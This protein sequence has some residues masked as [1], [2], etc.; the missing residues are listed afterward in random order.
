MKRS[1]H[2]IYRKSFLI[3]RLRDQMMLK[4]FMN[5]F[6]VNFLGQVHRS[7]Y[8]HCEKKKHIQEQR[9]KDFLRKSKKPMA[10]R[11]GSELYLEYT[12]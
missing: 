8:K 5:Y 12:V 4:A 9:E 3:S 7:C 6:L 1:G 2:S 10:L 11:R